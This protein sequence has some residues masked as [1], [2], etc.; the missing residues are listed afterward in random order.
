MTL[1]EIMVTSGLIGV[2]GLIIFSL[3]NIGTILGAKNSAVNVAH[4]QARTAMLQLTQDLR[5]SISPL[6]LFNAFDV[7]GKPIP[8]VNEDGSPHNGPAAGISFQLWSGGPY[9]IVEDAHIGDNVV[10]IKGAKPNLSANIKRLV[11]PTHDIEEDITAVSTGGCGTWNL[12]LA[13]PLTVDVKAT[14]FD[15]DYC[16]DIDNKNSIHITSFVADRCS[17]LVKDGGLQWRGPTTKKAFAMLGNGITNKTPF[18]TPV[19]LAGASNIRVVA[20]IDLSTEDSN[21][22]QRGFK[23]A[24]ILLN[25]LVPMKA[26]LADKR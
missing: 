9:R 21:Y 20:A 10:R 11:I 14:D 5:A 12:T 8:L 7:N 1:V 25:G 26:K 19:T 4:Q 3:L 16:N 13:N 17:Y 15:D 2:L 18:T 24:N 22:S 23:S 6:M